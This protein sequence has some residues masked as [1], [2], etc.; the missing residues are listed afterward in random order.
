MP[1]SCGA[2]EDSWEFL[3]LQ[4]DRTVNPKENQSWTFIGRTML[5]LKL[6][7]FGHLMWRA[8]GLE[9]TLMLGKIEGRRRRGRRK[10][11]WLDGITV[12][13]NM[14]LASSGKWWCTGKP[15]VLQSM[16]SQRVR[17][18]WVTEQQQRSHMIISIHRASDKMQHIQDKK[19]LAN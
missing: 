1:L 9:N 6:Q 5:K 19:I 7:Y 16:R 10:T 3:G 18:D 14:S 8:E 13:M 12:S 4:G 11:R 15:D 2:G 17:H